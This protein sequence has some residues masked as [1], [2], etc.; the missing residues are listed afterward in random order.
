MILLQASDLWKLIFE[1]AHIYV[2]GDTKAMAKDVHHILLS[3]VQLEVW[4]SMDWFLVTS[5][6]FD[7]YKYYIQIYGRY[8]E[9][10]DV[11]WQ[12]VTRINEGSTLWLSC[13]SMTCRD[14]INT[15]VAMVQFCWVFFLLKK[16]IG[17]WNISHDT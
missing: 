1:G 4:A 7:A 8:M 13:S 10:K 16:R 11:N 15:W 14:W 2:C 17:N 6:Q 12:F 9:V 5:I 3:I